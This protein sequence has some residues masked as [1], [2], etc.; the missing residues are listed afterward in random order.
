MEIEWLPFEL[1]PYPT[2]QYRPERDLVESWERNTYPVAERFGV[3][4]KLPVNISPYPYMTMPF[5]GFQFA[6]E[7]GK[8]NEYVH[9]VFQTFFV[10]NRNIGELEVLGEI[11][12]K[13][14]LDREAFLAALQSRRYKE[15][16]EAA[17]AQAEAFGVSVVPTLIIGDRVLEGLYDKASLER[18]IDQELAA[19]FTILGDGPLCGPD[20]CELP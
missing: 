7:H 6:K 16:H 14:G 9:E 19:G 1:R 11:A 10:E 3:P 15:A 18:I 8:G 17:L 20:G 12:G 13:V 4:I 5:E 2:P